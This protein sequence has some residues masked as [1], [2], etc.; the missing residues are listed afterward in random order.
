MSIA[1]VTFGPAWVMHNRFTA[2]VESSFKLSNNT[3]GRVWIFHNTAW[4]NQPNQNGMSPF[5]DFENLY[6][7]NNI[8]RGTNYALEQSMR[9]LPND[10]DYDNLFTTRGAPVIKWSDTR[11][12]TLA[13]LCTATGL[14]CNAQ[15]DDPQAIDPA[16]SRYA[17]GPASPNIDAAERLYGIN[18]SFEGAGPDIGYV[19]AGAVEVPPL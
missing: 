18:D 11:Y 17:P 4:T 2:F 7:R 10:L 1:P 6:F 15:P 19:E 9:A 5:G 16:N 13:D 12:D 8:V 14:E 3:T